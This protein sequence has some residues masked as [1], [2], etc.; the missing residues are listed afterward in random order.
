MFFY[1]FHK[2]YYTKNK[3]ITHKHHPKHTTKDVRFCNCTTSHT[4]P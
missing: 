2:K 4:M 1:I 3:H